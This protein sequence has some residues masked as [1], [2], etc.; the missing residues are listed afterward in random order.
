LP[1]APSP[2]IDSSPLILLARVEALPL[3]QS[4]GSLIL[5]PLPVAAEVHAKRDDPAS[6]ALERETWLRVVGIPEPD[7]AI[8]VW[9]LGAGETA[10]LSWALHHP[11]TLAILDDGEARKVAAKLAIPTLGTL[12]LVLKSKLE[13]R[14][15]FAR[16]LTEKLIASGMYLSPRI[17][18]EAL[19]LVGE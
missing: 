1:E 15:K 4:L 17:V 12:G 9:E 10:V 19:A 8:L 5:V 13:G 18:N 7:P 6:V 16:P 2:V 11:G 14:L 3:L